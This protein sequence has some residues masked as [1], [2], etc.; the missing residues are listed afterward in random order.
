LPVP[1]RDTESPATIDDGDTGVLHA[2]ASLHFSLLLNNSI[3]IEHLHVSSDPAF[4]W[5]HQES[6]A[7]VLACDFILVESRPR[8]HRP[9]AQ[10]LPCNNATILPC[11]MSIVHRRQ[12][13]KE[14]T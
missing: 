5:S 2:R 7:L 9:S 3:C 1:H 10:S 6:L 11:S 12:P 13:F 8:F 4:L 14:E